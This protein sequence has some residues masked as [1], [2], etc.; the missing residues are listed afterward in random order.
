M[1]KGVVDLIRVKVQEL[2]TGEGSGHDWEHIR[3]VWVTADKLAIEENAD[4]DIVA[5]VTLL[6]DVDDTKLTGDDSSEVKLPTARRIMQ[7]C[8]LEEQEIEN[9]CTILKSIGFRKRLQGKTP[10][11]LEANIVSDADMLDATGAIGIARCF[12]YSGHKGRAIF[13]PEKMP[14]VDMNADQYVNANA[15]AINHFFEKLVKLPNLMATSAG[16]KEAQ[17]R[18]LFL[19][20]YTRQFLNEVGAGQEW[21]DKLNELNHGRS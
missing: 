11:N 5:I 10:A 1:K 9:I 19:L 21:H 14:M 4:R 17:R 13:I 20:E 6:H 12:T 15:S 7:E 18:H 16:R 3:R 8:G 2:H